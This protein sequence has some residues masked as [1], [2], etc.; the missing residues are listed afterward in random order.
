MLM[1]EAPEWMRPLE[2]NWK[3]ERSDGDGIDAGM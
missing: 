3:M 1:V 2:A